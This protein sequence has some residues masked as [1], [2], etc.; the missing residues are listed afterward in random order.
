MMTSEQIAGQLRTALAAG[1][2]LAAAILSRTGWSDA[3]YRL[4]VEIAVAVVP[5]IAAAVWS[6]LAKTDKATLAQAAKVPGATVVVDKASASAG[7]KA[8]LAEKLPDVIPK[9]QS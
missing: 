4:Y 8:A 3:D 7:A 9:E 1:G 5:P 6:W 2:P